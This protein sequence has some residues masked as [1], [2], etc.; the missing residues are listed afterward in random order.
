[1]CPMSSKEA[2]DMCAVGKCTGPPLYPL[3]SCTDRA[4][5]TPIIGDTWTQGVFEA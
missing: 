1:M 5:G 2:P 3:E 4:G